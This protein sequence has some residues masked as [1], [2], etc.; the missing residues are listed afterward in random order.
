MRRILPSFHAAAR[1]LAL[2][3]DFEAGLRCFRKTHRHPLVPV[4]F[5]VPVDEEWPEECHGMKL[6]A[7]TG[8]YRAKYRDGKLVLGD[9]VDLLKLDFAFDNN[10]WKW[11]SRVKSALTT[12]KEVHDNLEVPRSF[13]VP[14]S[15]PWA[16]ETWGMLLGNTVNHI[17]VKDMYLSGDKPERRGWLNEIGFV[18]D[19]LE[20]RWETAKSALTMYKEVHGDLEVLQSFEVPSSAP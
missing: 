13:S 4:K 2:S 7:M 1:R 15:A 18:W 8:E 19:E 17:R 20:R 11:E 10:E 6:G 12:Y 5:I 16:E 9:M 3:A 14:S